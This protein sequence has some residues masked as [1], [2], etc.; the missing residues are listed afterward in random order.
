[1]N[2]YTKLCLQYIEILIILLG[3]TDECVYKIMYYV[4][5]TKT[6]F[7][8]NTGYINRDGVNNLINTTNSIRSKAL[9][10]ITII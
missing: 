8:I 5:F 1:M 7:S 10:G 9:L 3:G 6:S 4:H 2:V